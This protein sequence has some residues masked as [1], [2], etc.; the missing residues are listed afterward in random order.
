MSEDCKSSSV[1]N[2][3]Q[4]AVSPPFDQI[5][6]TATILKKERLGWAPIRKPRRTTDSGSETRQTYTKQDLDDVKQKLVF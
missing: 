4:R 5:N 6:T 2:N 3:S 1:G